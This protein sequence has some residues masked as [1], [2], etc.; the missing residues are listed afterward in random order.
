M[1]IPREEIDRQLLLAGN[2]EARSRRR[3]IHA[4]EIN[5]RAMAPTGG[6]LAFNSESIAGQ[7]PEKLCRKG[8]ALVSEGRSI[9]RTLTV[10][11]NLLLGGMIRKDKA[12]AAADLGTGS[13]NL[14]ILRTRYR[15]VA[16][17]LSGGEQQQLAIARAILQ[18]PSLMMID[19]PSLGL[20]P[21]VI[22][23]VY[24]SLRQ[25][26][27]SGLTLLVVERSTARILDLAS[28]VYVPRNGHNALEGSASELADGHALEKAYFD[29]GDRQTAHA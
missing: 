17:H 4:S 24:E 28:R 19:E 3:Q 7:A 13:G 2:D 5:F 25:L 21:L 23:Q 29:Y 6:T 18:R 16:G 12:E 10:R 27:A 8:L 11:E 20:A 26:N 1:S 15:G 14:P 22:D 9:F